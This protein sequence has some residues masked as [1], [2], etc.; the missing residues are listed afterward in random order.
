MVKGWNRDMSRFGK[1]AR[2]LWFRILIRSDEIGSVFTGPRSACQRVRS[3]LS[4][5]GAVN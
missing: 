2:L 3:F 1:V 4:R 5:I